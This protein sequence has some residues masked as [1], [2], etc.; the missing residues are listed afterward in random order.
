M[1]TSVPH[2]FEA[3]ASR[4][5]L[6][7]LPNGLRAIV[8]PRGIAPVA[9]FHTRVD[10]GSVDEREGI[11]GIAHMFEHMAFKGSRRIGTKNWELERTALEAEEKAY[12]AWRAARVAEDAQASTLHAQ[13]EQAQE[14]ALALVD[15]SEYS[16]AIT[17]AGGVGLNATTSGDSTNYFYSLPSNKLELW[18]WLESERFDDPVLREFYK[19]REVVREERR[20]RTDSSPVGKLVEEALL[21]AFPNHPYGR[22]VIGFE[23]DLVK[24]SRTDAEAFF[25]RKYSPSNMIVSIVGRV[26]PERAFET[27]ERYFGRLPAFVPEPSPP[28]GAPAP[29][30]R[31]VEV[32]LAAQPMLLAMLRRPAGHHPDDPVFHVLADLL[33]GGPH[34]RLQKALVKT[35]KAVHAQAISSFPGR[36]YSNAF[37]FLV[38]PSQ[39]VALEEAEQLL[40]KELERLCREGPSAAELDAVLQRARTEFLMGL[41]ANSGLAR[42]LAEFEALGGGWHEM[43]HQV[44]H[45]RAITVDR[46]RAVASSTFLREV[47]TTTLLTHAEGGRS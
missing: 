47:C 21:A 29:P 38:V 6:R 43:F 14:Q 9:S 3:L 5:A 4:V 33:A 27:V 31:R 11:T 20:M 35:G 7:R 12:L 28:E 13:F 10:V 46:V 24:F 40:W 34:A 19:E 26:E 44:E 8:V 25:R 42:E 36:K 18:A 37:T 22:P 39:G 30:A 2:E 45:I 23:A 15:S 17:R 16:E 41:V 1:T 32:R